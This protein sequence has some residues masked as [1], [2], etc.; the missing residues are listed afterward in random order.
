M[1]Y[2]RKRNYL[3]LPFYF[4]LIGNGTVLRLQLD[5]H[6]ALPLLAWAVNSHFQVFL[7]SERKEPA[8]CS[9]TAALAGGKLAVAALPLLSSAVNRIFQF[10]SSVRGGKLAIAALPPLSSAVKL[11]FQFSSALRGGKLET[12]DMLRVHFGW[13]LSIRFFILSSLLLLVGGSWV[14]A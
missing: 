8:N 7:R 12:A 10:S 3:I 9:F 11:I 2:K 14:G 13:S 1:G 5:T 4:T 6:T